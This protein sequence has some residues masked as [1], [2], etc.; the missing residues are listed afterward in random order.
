MAGV[1][2]SP[3]A[4]TVNIIM[5]A[6]A[7]HIQARVLAQVFNIWV[8]PDEGKKLPIIPKWDT[9]LQWSGQLQPLIFG[10][11]ALRMF[12]CRFGTDKGDTSEQSPLCGWLEPSVMFAALG[13]NLAGSLILGASKIKVTAVHGAL[14]YKAVK[15]HESNPKKDTLVRCC[16]LVLEEADVQEQAK[17]ECQEAGRY[18]TAGMLMMR[19]ASLLAAIS[20]PVFSKMYGPQ[21]PGVGPAC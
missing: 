9:Q 8:F 1:Q 20:F 3:I 10:L 12:L 2:G 4:F 14:R 6:L 13:L 7:L 11:G 16:Q 18:A 19:L 21:G 15:R 5:H 17:Q